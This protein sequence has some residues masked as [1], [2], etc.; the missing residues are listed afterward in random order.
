MPR[1]VAVVILL[2]VAGVLALSWPRINDVETGRTP[3]YPDL[4]PREFKS[5]PGEV[6]RAVEK[7]IRAIGWE[8]V[9]SGSGPK[10]AELR[11]VHTSIIRLREDVTARITTI[12][13]GT[14]LSVRSRSQQLPWDLGQN[15]RNIRELLAAVDGVH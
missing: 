3:E 10:G 1:R 14:R 7:A 5:A 6:S 12:P 13:G 2:L 8:F 4:R 9:G 15:A 11:A